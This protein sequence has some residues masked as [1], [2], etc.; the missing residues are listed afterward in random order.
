[1]ITSSNGNIFRVLAL[2]SPM[3]SAH[4][5]Q[6]RG[7]LMFSMLSKQSWG[8]WF[9]TP[10]RSLWR[11]CNDRQLFQCGAGVSAI[12]KCLRARKASKLGVIKRG[13][14]RSVDSP[15]KRT[16]YT[17][18]VSMLWHHHVEASPRTN[19]WW[20]HQMET[21]SALLAICAGNSPAPVNS[22]HKGQ[23]RGAL[24]FSL[25]CARINGWVNNREA[26]DLR[27]HPTHCDVIV[28]TLVAENP[29]HPKMLLLWIY[30]CRTDLHDTSYF[31][32]GLVVEVRIVHIAKI[33]LADSRY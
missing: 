2:W 31:K 32:M 7:A 19:T 26:G 14:N 15:H 33:V 11:H 29:N 24:M 20:R 21:V 9:E 3:N 25:I 1:M 12:L 22:P 13:I 6:W 16:S 28:M 10:S 4:K 30:W 18:S 27:R 8:W 5:G 23:W 17:E